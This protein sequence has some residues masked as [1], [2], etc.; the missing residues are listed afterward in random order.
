MNDI[1]ESTWGKYFNLRTKSLWDRFPGHYRAQVVETNDPLNIG[2]VKFRCPDIHDA[3]LAIELCPW[4]TQSPELGGPNSGR[5]VHPCIGDWIWITFERQHPYGPIWTGFADP[6]RARYYALPQIHTPT[7]PP[8]GASEQ[9]QDYQEEYL[10]KDGRPMTHGWQDR[11]GN[12]DIHS[13]VGFFPTTHEAKPSPAGHDAVQRNQ[14]TVGQEPQIN[15]P[16]RKFIARITKYGNMLVMGDQGY[17][18]KK[19]G[20]FGEF[21]GDAQTDALQE[22]RRWR[23]MQRLINEGSTSADQRRVGILTR[24]GHRIECRDVGWAQPGP[25]DSK[26]RAFEYGTPGYLSKETENDLRWIKI[27]TKG[28]MLLQMYDKGFDPQED[29]FIRRPLSAEQGVRSELED[30][31]WG[32]RDARWMRMVTRYGF[33]LVLDDRGSDDKDAR[34]KEDPRGIGILIKGRRSPAAKMREAVGDPRGFYWEFNERDDANHSMWGSPMGHAIE[35]N[36]RYQYLMLSSTMG[37]GW[38]RK[39]MGIKDNEFSRKPVMLANP[40]RRS[41]HLKLDHDN[42]YIRLKTRGGSGPTPESPAN[43]TGVISGAEINQGFEARDG[44]NG[45]G[46]WVELVDCQRRGMWFS[47][48]QRLSIWRSSSQ[49]RMYTWMD[50][51]QSQI[52]VLNQDGR[53][54][55]VSDATVDLIANSSVNINSSNV[56]NMRAG[57]SIRMQAGNSRLTIGPQVIQATQITE[58]GEPVEFVPRPNLPEKIEPE[59]RGATY[60]GPYLEAQEVS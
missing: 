32:D 44:N 49:R 51:V 4:A 25:R 42:E 24:Y 54:T 28:G 34:G 17:F 30:K 29:A 60:N 10:P 22:A 37:K 11:Y 53:I 36:D 47:K 13:S 21:E 59:D 15:N 38:T 33:K 40:E 27:R 39:W 43:P 26:S 55:I 41:H 2:R 3:D 45:D 14:F 12:A 20:E 56:I 9:I 18:W 8:S 46:P 23:Y 31:Y 5:F 19:E 52:V 16:D 35:L 1:A 6:T 7:V 58:G 50:E 57:A 48:R